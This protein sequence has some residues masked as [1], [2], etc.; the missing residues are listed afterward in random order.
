MPTPSAVPQSPRTSGT[1]RALPPRMMTAMSW[2]IAILTPVAL[3]SSVALMLVLVMSLPPETFKVAFDVAGLIFTSTGLLACLIALYAMNRENAPDHP[4]LIR[5]PKSNAAKWVLV[6]TV[7]L[8]GVAV[9][10]FRP[11]EPSMF[12]SYLIA[13]IMVLTL[14]Q[15]WRV[16]INRDY[17]LVLC[18]PFSF[19]FIMLGTLAVILIRAMTEQGLS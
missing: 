1:R 13:I 9:F 7:T 12:H 3:S 16:R 10:V 17:A 18:L 14:V 8:Y 15:T 2:S 19:I 4:A 6:L 5:L 11:K